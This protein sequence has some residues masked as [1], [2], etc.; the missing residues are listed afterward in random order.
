VIPPASARPPAQAP[1]IPDFNDPL[2]GIRGPEPS[3][4]DLL[5]PKGSNAPDFLPADFLSEKPASRLK[6]RSPE[7]SRT[8]SAC[9]R[10][11]GS[12]LQ[13]PSVPDHGPE[14]HTPYS[15]PVA[16]AGARAEAGAR[17]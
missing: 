17:R 12:R 8:F 4:D 11:R 14:I 1:R 9:F 7:V 15:P 16:K 10:A 5:G 2:A 6:L 13:G 3:I